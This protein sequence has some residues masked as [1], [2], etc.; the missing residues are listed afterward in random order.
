MQGYSSIGLYYPKTPENIGGVMRAAY[1]YESK[2]VVIQSNKFKKSAT[3]TFKTYKYIPVIRGKL[4]ELIP[5]DCVPVGVEIAEGA[6][7]LR[8]Y[9]H[10]ERAFYIFG[11]EDGSLNETMLNFCQDVVYIPTKACMNLAATA[12]VVLYDRYCKMK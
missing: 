6:T 8:D 11:P 12:N 3:D 10:P 4:K 2:L 9:T 1:C 5:Y 7:N